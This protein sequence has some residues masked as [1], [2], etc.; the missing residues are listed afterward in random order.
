M[1][2]VLKSTE[3]R[4]PV[5]DAELIDGGAKDVMYVIRHLTTD[6]HREITRQNTK[7]KPN[8][9]THQMEEH[10]DWA[11]VSDD[12]LDYVLTDWSGVIAE[13]NPLPCTLQYKLLLDAQRKTAIL[14]FAGMNEV[15]AAPERRAESFREAESVR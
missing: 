10:V 14:Q 8:K 4:Q 1:P 3:D 11:K 7:K 9:M 13:D 15:L 5:T 12:L 2:L 6:Q